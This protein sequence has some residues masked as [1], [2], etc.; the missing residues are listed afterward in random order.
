MAK[1][2]TS[3]PYDRLQGKP[4]GCREVVQ[5]GRESLQREPENAGSRRVHPLSALGLAAINP[6]FGTGS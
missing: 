1:S 6:K 3:L 2:P 5:R 4:V